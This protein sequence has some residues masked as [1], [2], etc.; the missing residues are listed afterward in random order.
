MKIDLSTFGIHEEEWKKE[1]PLPL[2]RP[3]SSRAS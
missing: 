3:F 1:T 2:P